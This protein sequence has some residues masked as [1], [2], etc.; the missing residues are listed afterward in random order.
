VVEAYEEFERFTETGLTGRNALH[1]AS[2]SVTDIMPGGSLLRG[3]IDST[4]GRMGFS[5][6]T[7]DGETA[8]GRRMVSLTGGGFEEAGS[9][10][11]RIQSG[12]AAV[13]D[14]VDR[15]KDKTDRDILEVLKNIY[16]AIS[17]RMGPGL[18][19]PSE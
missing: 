14:D 10:Y 12:I 11:D 2:R 17:R 8:A 5:G 7:A 15:E 13:G 1:L 19:R 6:G 16:E 3:A 4:L 18:T 9:G